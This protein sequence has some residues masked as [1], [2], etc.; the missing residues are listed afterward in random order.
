MLTHPEHRP[1]R[2]LLPPCLGCLAHVHEELRE[3]CGR[4]LRH[5]PL[6]RFPKLQLKLR[7]E[8]EMLLDQERA[9][10]QA[11]LE[12]L[13]SM[14]EAYIYTDDDKF[15]SELSAAVKKLVTRLDAPLLRSILNSYYATVQRTVTNSAPKAIML[16][17]V[18]TMQTRLYAYRLASRPEP[19]PRAFLPHA[20]EKDQ[21]VRVSLWW[22][23]ALRRAL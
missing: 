12:E 20:S 8:V 16:H 7:E 3:L 4:L 10:T 21:R 9:N 19:N 1:V 13:I 15:L 14:E 2:L 17:L 6:S 18:R 23:G 22:Q 11:K 5:A